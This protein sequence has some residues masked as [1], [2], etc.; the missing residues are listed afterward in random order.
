[1]LKK[2]LALLLSFP[3]FLLALAVFLPRATKAVGE[4]LIANPS[5]EENANSLPV[6]WTTGKWG[7][8]SVTFTYKTGGHTGNASV[9]VQMKSYSSGDAKWYFNPVSI[10]PSTQY[11]FSD[12]YISTVP[13]YLV[14][15]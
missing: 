4:N 5:V 10:L 3:I 12:Y 9:F 11:I 7:Q 8:N 2:V 14:A 1:M 13:T 15:Q 6:G